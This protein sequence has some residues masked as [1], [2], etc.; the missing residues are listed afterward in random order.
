M[1]PDANVHRLISDKPNIAQ[2][3]IEKYKTNTIHL[4][5]SQRIDA[6]IAVF[7]LSLTKSEFDGVN[8]RNIHTDMTGKTYQEA[9]TKTDLF[10]DH[11]FSSAIELASLKYLKENSNK[12]NDYFSNALDYLHFINRECKDDRF[13]SRLLYVALT[14]EVLDKGYELKGFMPNQL[15][16]FAN[17][18]IKIPEDT[19]NQSKFTPSVIYNFRS[20]NK[21]S[22]ALI[23]WIDSE[24]TIDSD[25]NDLFYTLY[26][27]KVFSYNCEKKIDPNSYLIPA[28]HFYHELK[29]LFTSNEDNLG[30]RI[31][32]YYKTK[33]G[34]TNPSTLLI[35]YGTYILDE[36]NNPPVSYPKPD[37]LGNDAI[38]IINDI[39][40]RKY[41]LFPN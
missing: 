12:K 10:T 11:L 31:R 22:N 5:D 35:D 37:K 41:G 17:E 38:N 6:L 15:K 34:V 1:I 30:D 32:D 9:S 19:P 7:N 4:T 24:K 16:S 39:K 13:E 2:V 8:F 29:N 25:M 26:F 21:I 40:D 3:N 23:S 28:T 36:A 20:V 14:K 33:R 27:T 18:L